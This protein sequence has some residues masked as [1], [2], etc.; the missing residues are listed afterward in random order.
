MPGFEEN[1]RNPAR[2]HTQTQLSLMT[3]KE[4]GIM[5]LLPVLSAALPFTMSEDWPL[6]LHPLQEIVRLIK[7]FVLLP[8]VWVRVERRVGVSLVRLRLAS[9]EVMP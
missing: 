8:V 4:Q 1:T 5:L 7:G 9:L 6:L 2:T 3:D